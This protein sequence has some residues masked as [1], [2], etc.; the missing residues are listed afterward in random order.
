MDYFHFHLSFTLLVFFFCFFFSL[1][2]EKTADKYLDSHIM[3]A[4]VAVCVRLC[5]G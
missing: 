2:E 5:A 3:Q 1:C 4:F